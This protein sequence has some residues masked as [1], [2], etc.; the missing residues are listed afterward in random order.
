MKQKIEA[1]LR[2]MGVMFSDA[3]VVELVARVDRYTDVG[4]PMSLVHVIARNWAIDQK[5]R[6]ERE[7]SREQQEK[8]KQAEAEEKRKRFLA[9]V[10]EYDLL[11][12][13]LT[14]NRPCMPKALRYMRLTCFF[15]ATDPECA[16]YFPESTRDQRYQWLK[17][18]RDFVLPHAS[19]DLK[20]V[21]WQRIGTKRKAA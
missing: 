10:A 14:S 11:I 15:D 16:P 3:D 7:V 12:E 6:E 5:R 19:L 21:L 8:I 1:V 17:R 4:S 18:A 13:T 9:A 20:A 2:S